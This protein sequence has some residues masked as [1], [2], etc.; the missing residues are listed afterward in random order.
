MTKTANLTQAK[1]LHVELSLLSFNERVLS[2]AVD[3]TTPLL[4]RLKYLCIFSSNMDEFFEIRVSGL[5]AKADSAV[6]GESFDGLSPQLA[7]EEI[8]ACAHDLVEL[9]YKTLNQSVFPLMADYGIEFLQHNDWTEEQN[10][11]I[12]TYFKREILPILT[13]IRLDPAHPFPLTINKGLSIIV[14][15]HDP[16]RD[17]KHNIAIVPAPRA[18]PRFIRLPKELC[19]SEYEYVFLSSIIHANIK[20]L[21]SNVKVLGCYQFRITRNS[22]P[23]SYTH[24]TLPT[25]YSV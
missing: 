11:W 14:D 20:R 23:V 4:E 15:L 5:K 16:E 25:I 8:S 12:K 6:S 19:E 18:L 17:D 3:P 7:L 24:L 21:F 10:K 2:M 22:D 13:P 1:F 9:Q